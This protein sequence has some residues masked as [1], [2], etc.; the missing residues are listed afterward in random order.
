MAPQAMQ[1]MSAILMKMSY[2][3]LT[4]K[5]FIKIS[6]VNTTITPSPYVSLLKRA[7]I[8]FINFLLIILAYYQIKPASRSLF[9]EY[10]G[11]DYL[12]YVWIGT[13]LVLGT[14]ISYQIFG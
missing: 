4:Q 1:A 8:L 13:A 10:L 2:G 5:N 11:A 9:I 14:S 3:N 12:P 6:S 7:S